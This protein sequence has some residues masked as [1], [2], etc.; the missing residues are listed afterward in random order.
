MQ[1]TRSR[2]AA[3]RHTLYGILIALYGLIISSV[4]SPGAAV[5]QPHIEAWQTSQGARVLFVRAPE[6][7]MLDIR[8]VFAAGSARDQQAA[9]LAH[10][11]SR[12]LDDGAGTLDAD[13]IAERFEAVGAMFGTVAERDMAGADLRTLSDPA[14]AAAA[15]E[16]FAL[17]LGSPSFPQ[18][19]FERERARMQVGANIRQQSLGAVASEAF[20]QAVYQEHPYAH[21]PAGTAESLEAL[22]HTQV[23]QFYQQFYTAQNAV[24]AI[25]GDI[26][27]SRAESIAESLSANLPQGAAAPAL[28]PVPPLTEAHT[29]RQ[30]FPASQ[31]HILLGQPGMSRDDPLYFPLYVGN[32]VLGGSGLVSLLFHEVR[33]ERGLSYNVYSRF[34]PMAQRGPFVAGLQTRNDQAEPAFQALQHTL[35]R[36]VEQGPDA[37]QLDLAQKNL[38]GSFPLQINS[39]RKMVEILAMIGFYHLPLDYLERFPE[40]VRMVNTAAVQAA[41]QARLQP[42]HF[43]TVIVGGAVSA[44]E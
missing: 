28:P 3:I 18:E 27:R 29:L 25:V 5:A 15:L 24:L 4:L 44:T 22:Q 8:M 38:I 10:L 20:W 36:F 37:A 33:A 1:K 26:N 31:T 42:Q 16:T 19:A 9:G 43:V 12:L 35:Q 21:P 14:M 40:R 11:T 23:V 2:M 30:S 39:N 32:H 7:P 13:T 34:Q 17:V 41:F 6:L